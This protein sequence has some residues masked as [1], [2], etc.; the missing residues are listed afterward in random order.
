MVRLLGIID[1]YPLFNKSAV[2][3]TSPV[4]SPSNDTVSSAAPKKKYRVVIKKTDFEG[5]KKKID[6]SS[7]MTSSID[8]TEAETRKV[9]IDAAL[10]EAGWNVGLNKG[11]IKAGTARSLTIFPRLLTKK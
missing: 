11:V 2:P 10:K 5:Y 7:K 3:S 9:F 8:F 4:P 6:A 1:S